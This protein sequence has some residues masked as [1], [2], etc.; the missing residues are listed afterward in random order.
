MKPLLLALVILAA[1]VAPAAAQSPAQPGDRLA[2]G[3]AAPDLAT[4]NAY[5]YRLFVDT[6][7]VGVVAP[8]TCAGASSPFVCVANLPPLTTG[9]HA[10]RVSAALVRADGTDTQGPLSASF[11]FSLVALPAAPVQ[12]RIV[13]GADE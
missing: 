11:T 1:L 8:S 13:P 4:A 6:D 12:L 7:T 2:W 5:R 10:V 9:S 3:Q